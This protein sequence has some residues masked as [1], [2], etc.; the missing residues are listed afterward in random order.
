MTHLLKAS[1]VANRPNYPEN[2]K[3]LAHGVSSR[4]RKK[5]Q[6]V[7]MN[8]EVKAQHFGLF[9]YFSEHLYGFKRPLLDKFNMEFLLGLI[10]ERSEERRVGKECRAR[11]WTT[12]YRKRK[13]KRRM[14]RIS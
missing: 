1:L 10:P 6:Y 5:K 11:R 13:L 7:F 8:D 12:H 4:K 9:P 2:T 3:V 14:H